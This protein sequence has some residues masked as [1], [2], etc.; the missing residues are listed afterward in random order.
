MAFHWSLQFHRIQGF[1]ILW[2]QDPLL[3]P[4]IFSLVS[5]PHSYQLQ[6]FIQPNILSS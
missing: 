6:H 4:S 5:H 2:M 1:T 3:L